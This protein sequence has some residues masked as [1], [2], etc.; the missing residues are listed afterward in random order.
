MRP[1]MKMCNDMLH[2]G[3]NNSHAQG[4]TQGQ[5]AGKQQRKTG[6]AYW[7]LN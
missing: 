6:R 7:I 1:I 2:L 3:R 5:Q 4:Q